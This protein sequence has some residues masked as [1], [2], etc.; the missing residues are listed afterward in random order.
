MAVWAF[1]CSD[2][3]CLP[4]GVLAARVADLTAGI[5]LVDDR[6]LA[7]VPFGLVFK[8]GAELS[9]ACVQNAFVQTA[10]RLLPV[11]E[12]P[13]R[14][15]RVSFR[16]AASAHV[17]DSQ[18]LDDN[19]LVFTDDSG[20]ELVQEVGTTIL[21]LRVCLR[22][23]Q[24]GLAIIV[25]SFLFLGEFLLRQSKFFQMVSHIAWIVD[26]LTIAEDGEVF[27]SHVDADHVPVLGWLE[28]GI[29]DQYAD[30]PTS[31]RVQTDSHAGWSAF[32]WQG[33][34]P[35]YMQWFAHLRQ[36][37]RPVLPIPCECGD[38]VGGG[39]ALVFRFESRIGA[40]L[41]EEPLEC[42]LQMP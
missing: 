3:Q 5:P 24:T 13:S 12:V 39:T 8:H 6:E 19:R 30:V 10:F 15:V 1:P 11:V 37:Q 9:P 34:R 40:G 4:A 25:A 42:G 16:L 18:V 21:D 2:V 7:S 23:F 35:T 33:A 38:G 31:S 14:I 41:V 32:S 26:F 29:F 27:Q 17:L 28:D 36:R 22:H 20:R